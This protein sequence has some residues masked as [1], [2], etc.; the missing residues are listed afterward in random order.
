MARLHPRGIKDLRLFHD[1]EV[2]EE[3]GV[4]HDK[5]A[6]VPERML[7]RTEC[8]D[9]LVGPLLRPIRPT[10]R[11]LG[12]TPRVTD[13]EKALVPELHRLDDRVCVVYVGFMKDCVASNKALCHEMLDFFRKLTGN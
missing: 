9:P 3:V 10:A 7:K 2:A 12:R 4:F 8:I 6:I 13:L 11:P 5:D 1:F